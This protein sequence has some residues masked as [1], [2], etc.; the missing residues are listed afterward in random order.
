MTALDCI[1][2]AEASWM[3]PSTN[4]FQPL[5]GA[6]LGADRRPQWSWQVAL[7]IQALPVPGLRAGL[8]NLDTSCSSLHGAPAF[9]YWPYYQVPDCGE[10]FPL[11]FMGHPVQITR[12]AASPYRGS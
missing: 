9:H 10:S 11:L 6:I 2:D 4:A 8:P 1:Q 7:L 12:R 3:Y 5:G